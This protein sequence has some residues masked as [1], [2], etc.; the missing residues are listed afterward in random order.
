MMGML[1]RVARRVRSRVMYLSLS[2][3]G[4]GVRTF[5]WPGGMRDERTF[6]LEGWRVVA[7][8]HEGAEEDGDVADCVVSDC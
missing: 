7:G 6:D 2:W 3:G 5:A 4:V 8:L 1:R